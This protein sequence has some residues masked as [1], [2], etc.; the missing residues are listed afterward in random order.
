[1]KT[2]IWWIRRD[3]RLTD[4]QALSRAVKEAKDVF[5]IFILDPKLIDSSYVGEKRLSFL[6][7]GLHQLNADLQELGS[8][9]II[10][11]GHPLEVFEELRQQTDFDAIYAEEDFS[12]YAQKRDWE[13]RGQFPIE[14]LG[15][16]TLRHPLAV[17]KA[18]GQPYSVFTPYSR[19]WKS[20]PLPS[21]KDLLPKP[22]RVRTPEDLD[23][24][25]LPPIPAT[26][27][28]STFTAGEAEAQR[29]LKSFTEGDSAPVYD[30]GSQRDRMDLDGTSQLSPYLRFGMLSAKQAFL[31]T[32]IAISK[33]N[34]KEDQKSANTW[35]NELIWREFFQSILFNFPLVRKTS[36]REN[37][38]GIEWENNPADF[39]AW[40][41]GETG[42]PIVDA[43]MRQLLE[44]GW[45]HNRAR[46]IVASFL[47]K[48]LLI[49]WRWG[50]RWFM[51]HL[52][53]GDPAANNG[54][55]QWSA[56]TGTDAAPYFRIFNPIL[57]GQ[58]FDPKGDY[59][60]RWVPELKSVPTKFVHKPWEMSFEVQKSTSCV[61]GKHYPHPIIDHRFARERALERF[62]G[63][64]EKAS[65]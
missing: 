12:P 57:Q 20:L 21:D 44:T 55:W 19:A 16:P 52:I 47:V 62:R 33:S 56:G 36:F 4:N 50:E 58:K 11:A 46:M 6:Y 32:A 31:A 34:Q 13:V 35:F 24:L 49:D 42:Y 3:L 5:P 41:S 10:R 15:H 29:R 54:G 8:R 38:R 22:Q 37:L 64:K 17:R 48:D 53:D 7:A 65:T 39:K 43:A 63:A 25:P 28:R 18:N 30:Y 40:C 1:M 60:Y 45:M 51:T 2:I 23:M 9:L 61:L 27:N 59:V 14:F 26:F